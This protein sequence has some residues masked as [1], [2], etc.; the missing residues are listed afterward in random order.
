MLYAV[1]NAAELNADL[2]LQTDDNTV[3]ICY[4]NPSKLDKSEG[5]LPFEEQNA[6]K[7]ERVQTII[8]DGVS[9]CRTMY[10]NGQN[11]IYNYNPKQATEY[12]YE[13]QL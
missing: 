10:P 9:Y 6:W 2:V 13:Y 12:N 11:N 1:K 8:E 5:H 4:L 7:I 3:Y